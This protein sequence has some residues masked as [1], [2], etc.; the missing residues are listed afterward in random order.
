MIRRV[1]WSAVIAA[2]L[3]IS[4]VAVSLFDGFDSTVI[5]L[6]FGAVTAA[7]LANRER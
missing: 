1:V 3:G 4:A 6:G 5:A 7:L 2:V